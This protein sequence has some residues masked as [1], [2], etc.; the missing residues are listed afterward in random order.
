M[1]RRT[2]H[3]RT[4]RRGFALRPLALSIALAL[5]GSLFAGGVDP[6]VAGGQA[7]VSVDGNTTTVTQGSSRAIIDWRS[8]SLTQQEKFRVLQGSAKDVLL[9][10]IT[11]S[12]ASVL[13][14]SIQALGRVYFLNPNGIIFGEHAQID[15]GGLVAST[16]ALSNEDFMAGRIQLT[17]TTGAGDYAGRVI[18]RGRI[19]AAGGEIVL[20]GLNVANEGTLSAPGGRVGLVAADE[21]LVDVEGDGLLFFNVKAADA[22]ARV[23]Q[24]GR[25]EADGGTVQLRAEARAGFADTVL[26]LDGVVQARSLGARNGRVVVDGG[27][28]GVTE[29]AGSIDATGSAAGQT[30]GRITV[31]GDRSAAGGRVPSTG[32]TQT[33][34]PIETPSCTV[35]AA[36]RSRTRMSG[37]PAI[38]GITADSISDGPADPPV[39]P[40]VPAG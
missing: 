27:A 19:N 35:V 4:A 10:R 31:T 20:A 14:G 9:N 15:V 26:N 17:P 21:V 25:I 2:P 6:T 38:P 7:A 12:E 24:L 11:G 1:R 37:S 32:I 30:G 5:P 16:L 8:L 33:T 22:G 28:A 13:D 39:E 18:N 40:P 36:S 29:V 3:A 23:A 34:S